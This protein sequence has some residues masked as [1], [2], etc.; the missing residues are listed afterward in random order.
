MP[1][2]VSTIKVLLQNVTWLLLSILKVGI[3][4]QLLSFICRN[5]VVI[6]TDYISVTRAYMSTLIYTRSILLRQLLLL[7]NAHCIRFSTAGFPILILV[8]LLLVLVLVQMFLMR[9][10]VLMFYSRRFV[11]SK[12]IVL[13]KWSCHK[14]SRSLAKFRAL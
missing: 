9:H 5:P 8:A 6:F 11:C 14:Y 7:L 4:Y 13:G 10:L 12:H 2:I 3:I 1:I